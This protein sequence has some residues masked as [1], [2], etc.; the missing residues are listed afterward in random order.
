MTAIILDGHLQSALA[1]VRSLG[2]KNIKVICG[3]P[4]ATAMSLFSRFCSESFVYT[5]AGLDKEK[6]ISDLLNVLKRLNEKAIIFSFS[7]ETFLPV[8]EEREKIEPYAQLIVSDKKS[9]D[10]AFNKEKTLRLA[11]DNNIPI[12][13]THFLSNAEETESLVSKLSYPLIIKPC[14]SYVW[15]KGKGI[16]GTT[17]YINSPEKLKEEFRNLEA[18]MGEAP[19]I[20]ELIEGEEFGIFGLFE[21]GEP[22]ALFAHKRIRS[23]SPLGGASVLRESIKM[24]SEMK[25]YSLKLLEILQWHGPAMVEFKVDKKNGLPKLMEINGRFWGS[26]PLAIYS[27]IDFPYF[28]YQMAE[29]KNIGANFGY[30][31][32]I[33]SR[34]LLADAKNLLSVLFDK[35]RVEGVKFPDKLET[36]ADFFTFFEKDL[37]YDVESLN[38]AKPFFMEIIDSFVRL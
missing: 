17:V 37:H 24:P 12:P 19:L 32:N 15:K 1:A 38:D 3:A 11:E 9:I 22:L 20:Q 28:F 13:E 23:I 36:L 4:R 21:H 35:G 14:Q 30:K 18:K 6:F 29:G 25:E 16:L 31:E 33:R 5:P 27:G 34:H 2:S 26:L 8:S 7:D 10:I